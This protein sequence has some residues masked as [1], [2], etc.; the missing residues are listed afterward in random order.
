MK[1]NTAPR[2]LAHLVDCGA[3]ER[4]AF[5]LVDVGASAGIASH[6]RLFGDALHA[7]GFDLLVGEVDR[8]NK[9]E[10]N[11]N[12]RYRA[13]R[14]GYG[15]Y[16]EL[17][18]DC[19]AFSSA[20]QHRSS[21]QRALELL[22]VSHEETY[23]QTHS[24]VMSSELVE[25]DDTFLRTAPVNVD[26]VKTDADSHDY[27]VLLGA[28]ELLVKAPVL[29]LLVE[30]PFSGPFHEASTLFAN[31]DVLLRG[32]G[33]SL[34]DFDL[35]RYSRGA[36]PKPFRWM[37]P[38][39]TDSGQLNWAD[40]LYLRDVGIQGYEA[41]WGISLAPVKLLKLCCLYELHGLQDCAAEVLLKYRESLSG[42]VDVDLC[43][44][45]LTPALPDGR[46]VSYR[47]YIEFFEN[48]VTA[49]YSGC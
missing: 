3:L 46:Q 1:I 31:V 21:S 38:C 12:V 20:I 8:L 4:E 36:L 41:H 48:N 26:F 28:R 34:F 2:L 11:P 15:G 39:E 7:V 33:F 6:W 35:K 45:L 49:F 42:L 17:I 13:G 9:V 24:G 27:E 16:P 37:Q 47:E 23:D 10:P 32:L 5:S 22:R 43:L 19:P 14:V 18:A 30:A 40:C 29:G 25:L 44:D